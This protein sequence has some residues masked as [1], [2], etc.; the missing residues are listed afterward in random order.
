MKR[1]RPDEDPDQMNQGAREAANVVELSPDRWS[2]DDI[3]S[4]LRRRDPAAAAALFE[5]FGASINRQVW[6]LLGGDQDH[7]DVVHQVFVNVLASLPKL[8]NP[9]SLEP[10]IARITIN[11]V[12]KTIRS[13][14]VRRILVPVAE[15]PDVR[16]PTDGPESGALV[17]RFY[18]ILGRMRTDDHLV[19][20]LRFVA[21]YSLAEVAAA[22]GY[23]LATA[24]RRIARARQE[25]EERASEDPL[26]GSL[27]RERDH[28]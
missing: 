2:D 21:G 11:T 24:K 6:R 18:E 26:L 3:V 5:R 23:S 14:K 19:F 9:A 15:P 28:D 12:R 20:A 10:W 8:T 13:R 22:G 7:D 17:K 25:F 1:K 16:D 27:I 4:G